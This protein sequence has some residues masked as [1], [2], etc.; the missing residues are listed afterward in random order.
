MPMKP[1]RKEFKIGEKKTRSRR[2]ISLPPTIDTNEA[3]ENM[4]HILSSLTKPEKSETECNHQ[5]RRTPHWDH[6]Y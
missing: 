2:G 1:K 3:E 5:K 4:S 6:L